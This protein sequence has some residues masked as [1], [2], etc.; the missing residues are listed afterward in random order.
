[1]YKSY[2][3]FRGIEQLSISICWRLMAE[4]VGAILRQNFVARRI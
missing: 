4:C 1:M 2:R 3:M